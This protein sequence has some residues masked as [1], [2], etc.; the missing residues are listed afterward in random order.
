VTQIS[1]IKKEIL[2]KE[3]KDIEVFTSQF[4]M[5]L[6]EIKDNMS[7]KDYY[8]ITAVVC[9]LITVHITTLIGVDKI[10]LI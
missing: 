2:P 1:E 6:Q 10:I 3:A 7:K 4:R 8:P 5:I 9:K